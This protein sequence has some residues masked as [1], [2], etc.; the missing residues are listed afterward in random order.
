MKWTAI[1][2]TQLEKI[3]SES[4]QI[5]SP[6]E[7]IKFDSIRVPLYTVDCVRG[8]SAKV[9]KVFVVARSGKKIIIYD[10]V[11]DEFAVATAPDSTTSVLAKE[12]LNKSISRG[13]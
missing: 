2:A 4:L 13:S 8:K 12:T 3:I 11:E 10:D 9:E 6:E 1:T 7:K 5:I